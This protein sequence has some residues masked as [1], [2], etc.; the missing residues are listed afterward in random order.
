MKFDCKVQSGDY[1]ELHS[2]VVNNKP[3]ISINSFIADWKTVI[4]YESTVRAL[5]EEGAQHIMSIDEAIQ[6]RDELTKF[7][8][9]YQRNL[10]LG[11]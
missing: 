3:Q 5:V 6:L 2:C 7:I 8:T 4:D 10:I 1:I 9:T 11:G